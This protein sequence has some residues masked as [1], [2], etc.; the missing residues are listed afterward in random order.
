MWTPN[1]DEAVRRLKDKV[2]SPRVLAHYDCNAETKISADASSH[3][4]RAVLLQ[5][6]DNHDWKSVAFALRS[7]TDTEESHYAQIKKD[8]LALVWS[9]E[10]F[11]DYV[12]GKQFLFET[13]HKPLVPL[14]GT[15]A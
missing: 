4:L 5:Q 14:P 10:K 2:S 9:C 11:S 13:N 7:L 1:H 15:N 3:D 6:Q 8:T 12:L